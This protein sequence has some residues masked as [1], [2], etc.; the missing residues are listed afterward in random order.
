MIERHWHGWT[1]PEDADAYEQLLREEVFADLTEEIDGY[2][3]VRVLRRE[4]GD[5]VEFCT[6]LRFEAI[7]AVEEFAGQPAERA[8]VPPAAQKLLTRYDDYATH[9]ELRVDRES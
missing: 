1:A 6:M 9:Y 5:E 8:H 2:H 7:E 3:G 4:D